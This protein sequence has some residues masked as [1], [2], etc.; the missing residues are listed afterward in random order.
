MRIAIISVIVLAGCGSGSGSPSGELP[1]VAVRSNATWQVID[2]ETGTVTPQADLPDLVADPAYRDRKLALRLVPA[3]RVAVGTAEQSF[4]RQDDEARTTIDT[5][6][7]YIAA[8]ELTRAQWQ[9]LAGTTP[10]TAFGA[11]GASDLPATGMTF[12]E[13]RTVLVAWSAQHPRLELPHGSEWE[14]AA[15]G[16]STASFPWGEERR[17]SIAGLHALTWD[18][19]PNATGPDPVGR[20]SAN[21]FGLFDVAGNVWELTAE[22]TMR[23]GSWGDALALAR[24]ANQAAIEPDTVHPTVGLRV[25]YRP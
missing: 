7:C 12:L 10:W 4:A 11:G 13:A 17:A 18:S 15:R 14:I 20:R 19:E 9:R 16:G 8:F 24:P 5:P 22:G 21:G 6:G 1:A 2:L 25:V 3:Q 23:G